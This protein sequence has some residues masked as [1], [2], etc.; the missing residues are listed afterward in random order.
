VQWWNG[1]VEGDEVRMTPEEAAGFF[2]GVPR[3]DAMGVLIH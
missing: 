1:Q 2:N 3:P